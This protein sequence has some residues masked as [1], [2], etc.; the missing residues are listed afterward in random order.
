MFEAVKKKKKK[1]SR[2]WIFTVFYN[3]VKLMTRGKYTAE[4][5]RNKL[6]WLVYVDGK[7]LH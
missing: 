3:T 2:D 5:W 7:R 4:W 1:T 6:H